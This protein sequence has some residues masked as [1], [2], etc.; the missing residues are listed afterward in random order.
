MSHFN[1]TR[2]NIIQTLNLMA[3]EVKVQMENLE[4]G[5][6]IKGFQLPVV[7]IPNWRNSDI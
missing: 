3:V 7:C 6:D 2:L 4:L 5:W 1:R